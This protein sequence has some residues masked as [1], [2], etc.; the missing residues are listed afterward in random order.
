M[1]RVVA[2]EG[3]EPLLVVLLGPTASGKT[4]LS[5]ALA[6]NFAGEVVSCDSVA[7]YRELEIGTAKPTPS[8][9]RQIPHHLIDVASPTD[10]YTAGDYSRRAR[11]AISGIT[12]RGNLPIVTGG[13]GLYL[14]ALIDGLFVGPERSE[15]LRER[16]RLLT[17]RHGE[18]ALHRVLRRLDPAS[19]AL[20]HANDTPKLIRAIEV[21]LTAGKP[22]SEAWQEGRDRLQGY[23]ILRIGLEPERKALYAR[24]NRRAEEMFADG[25]VA[26]TEQLLAKYGNECRPLDSLGYKQAKSVLNG[27]MSV[28]DAIHAAQQGHRNYAKR[29]GTWFRREP[30]VHWL[31]GFGNDEEIRERASE[32]VGKALQE[33]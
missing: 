10:P 33:Q 24:I 30:E 18:G 11:A 27:T 28:A 31:S 8:E 9:R 16:L 15:P 7:V 23:R 4:S 25:L 26:E 22:M 6:E 29:Q 20:I 13:T 21:S 19:A 14:R 5:L 12:S 1:A 3:A 2:A 17:A 32:L